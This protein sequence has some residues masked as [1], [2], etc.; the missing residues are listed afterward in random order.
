MIRWKQVHSLK[1][2]AALMALLLGLSAALPGTGGYPGLVFVRAEEE[3]GENLTDFSNGEFRQEPLL[4]NEVLSDAG[5]TSGAEDPADGVDAFSAENPAN[6]GD[7]SGSENPANGGN[8]AGSENPVAG[9]SEDPAGGDVSGAEDLS[10]DNAG[11]AE[12][13]SGSAEN[14]TGGDASGSEDPTG[15]DAGGSEN[16]T[17]SDVSG[18]ED[19]AGGD[20]G[21]SEDPAGGDASGAE[22]PAGSDA[23]STENP[24]GGDATVA[25]DP[26]NGG[27]ASGAENPMG[28]GT[29]AED[30]ANGFET[31]ASEDPLS[32]ETS[33]SEEPFLPD[34]TSA[35]ETTPE[36]TSAEETT[37]EETT[38]EETA[39]PVRMMLR[40]VRAAAPAIPMQTEAEFEASLAD[41]PA[42][43]H[44]GLRAIH[45]EYPN[46]RFT[47]DTLNTSWEDAIEAE[48]ELGIS[49]IYTGVISSLKSTQK[50]AYNW[51][52][53][54]WKGM[55]GDY[56]VTASEG[57]VRYY[58]DPR[59]YLDTRRVFAFL[60][61]TF[62]ADTQTVEG[63][64]RMVEG[65]YL[66]G[67]YVED[68]VEYK[69][70]DTIMKAAEDSGMNPYLIAETIIV[71]NGRQGQGRCISGT[72]A[73]YEG[74]YNFFNI[75]AYATSTM[76]TIERGLWYASRNST[77]G[78]PWNTRQK[79]ITG[80]C[81]F[82]MENYVNRGQNT[83]YKKK[84]FV[85]NGSAS[86]QYM[87][88]VQGTIT[89]AVTLASA[90]SE[91]MKAYP[92]KFSIPVYQDM[93]ASPA[94]LPTGDG[95]PDNRLSS[96]KVE[97]CALT[98][99]FQTDVLDYTVSTKVGIQ[100]VKITAAAKSSSATV[101]GAGE[102]D[103]QVGNNT[104]YVSV[105]A[106]N[107]QVRT[108]TLHME[109]KSGETMIGNVKVNSPL[110]FG[111]SVVTGLTPGFSTDEFLRSMSITGGRAELTKADGSG[112]PDRPG[113]G[114]VLTIYDNSG[115]KAGQYTLVLF[116]DANG[117]GRVTSSDLLR[118][119]KSILR[120]IQIGGNE[121]KA[122]DANHDGRV[123]SSDLLRIQKAILGMETILQEAN[124]E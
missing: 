117:D 16:P 74:Y 91:E 41:F 90:Y 19:P 104:I 57:A 56:W 23:G 42:S 47:A 81:L 73:G 88:N 111:Q 100:F 15:S 46:W 118:I 75:G 17:G 121:Q 1:R 107:G 64:E 50:G 43:Y 54:V 6:S 122:A 37:A 116:G 114:T 32:G 96:L 29:A 51:D 52:T 63:V 58:L 21:G 76:G 95:S 14:P 34:E 22:D 31:S 72:V 68:N 113:T 59:I 5:E 119:Q 60:D 92:L 85:Q 13:P 120:M 124:G 84:F 77:Y 99:S 62:D 38:E 108:Y 55:D 82:Y 12:V 66:T 69:Y 93:P 78:R 24:A 35:E 39:A 49:C 44:A 61:Y 8:A 2:C 33:G 7:S 80:G 115:A 94:S 89:E 26:A 48:T 20:A 112:T 70:V 65:T 106:Q 36:E 4:G 30:P 103:V 10:G 110:N 79:S 3:N 102:V 53:G 9:G 67:T 71:E 40:T 97:G 11:S 18:A 105:K 109:V 98:P 25:E 27:A 83:L 101:S 28:D 87:T 123:T 86:H 45:A